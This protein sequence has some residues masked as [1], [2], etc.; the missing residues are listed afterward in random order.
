MAPNK[1][2]YFSLDIKV[3]QNARITASEH[4]AT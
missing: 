4:N 1:Q 2:E 3:Y